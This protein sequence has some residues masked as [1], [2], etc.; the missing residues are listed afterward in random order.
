MPPC[1]GVAAAPT[2]ARSALIPRTVT[3]M[4]N[5]RRMSFPFESWSTSTTNG[6][7][8]SLPALALSLF[9]K[10]DAI[11]GTGGHDDGIPRRC[12]G[13]GKVRGVAKTDCVRHVEPV[14][15]W[16]DREQRGNAGA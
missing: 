2:E 5:E 9:G 8:D 6:T 10:P 11:H 16:I 3:K 1:C 4:L 14:R 12:K 13:H 7:P 15:E